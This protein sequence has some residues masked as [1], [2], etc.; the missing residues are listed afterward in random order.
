MNK[1]RE[2]EQRFRGGYKWTR[3]LKEFEKIKNE[4]KLVCANCHI[5]IHLDENGKWPYN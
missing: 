1:M 5:L 2:E 3:M 4:L